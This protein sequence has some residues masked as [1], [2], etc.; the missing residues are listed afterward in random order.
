MKSP[1]RMASEKNLTHFAVCEKKL[2]MVATVHAFF[3][4][5][6]NYYYF[7]FF[8]LFFDFWEE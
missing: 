8:S 1:D 5:A 7:F 2:L 4:Q 6:L 3:S